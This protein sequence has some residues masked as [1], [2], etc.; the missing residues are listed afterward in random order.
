MMQNVNYSMAVGEK[1][2]NEE[3]KENS[4]EYINRLYKDERD[5]NIKLLR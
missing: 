4:S 5:I 3:M 2:Q 1:R